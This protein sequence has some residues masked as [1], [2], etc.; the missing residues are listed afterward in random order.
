MVA[1]A[2]LKLQKSSSL[3][4]SRV[5]IAG[6]CHTGPSASL[7]FIQLTVLAK[8]GDGMRWRHH[9]PKAKSH[10]DPHPRNLS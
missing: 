8:V 5:R 6:V 1:Q 4:L 2:S 10:L 9:S 7:V 3:S